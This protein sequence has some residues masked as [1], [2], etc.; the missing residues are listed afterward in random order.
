MEEDHN[1]TY[2]HSITRNQYYPILKYQKLH[3]LSAMWTLVADW[4]VL[5]EH[6]NC[7]SKLRMRPGR[8]RTWRKAASHKSS[9]RQSAPRRGKT[10]PTAANWTSGEIGGDC[11]RPGHSNWSCPGWNSSREIDLRTE[12][13]RD[14]NPAALCRFEQLR[15]KIDCSFRHTALRSH[16]S[17]LRSHT[18]KSVDKQ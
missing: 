13:V 18:L 17:T 10:S 15:R 11:A 3:Q 1:W 16:C 2:Y 6:W 7:E 14:S 12:S 9:T 4:I 5:P 8:R